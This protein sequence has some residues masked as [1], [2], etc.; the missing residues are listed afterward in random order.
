MEILI[1]A[2]EEREEKHLADTR[3]TSLKGATIA[4]VDDN[5]DTEFT[6]E[7]EAE[8]QRTYGA[9][10]KRLVKPWGSAASPKELIEEAARCQAAVVGIAL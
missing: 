3:L 8:L 4:L 10:V 2:Y 9:L 5:Y 7:L 1:P 6:E